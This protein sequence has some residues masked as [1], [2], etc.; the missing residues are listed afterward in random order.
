M[1]DVIAVTTE[2]SQKYFNKKV[3]ETGYPIRADLAL[4]DRKRRPS[5]SA[6]TAVCPSCWCSAAA[7]ARSI[8][9]A[10]LNNLKM[11]CSKI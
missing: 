4:W 3:Y 7:R 1:A 2:E 8:N 5:T 9:M 6:S 10:V 11:P